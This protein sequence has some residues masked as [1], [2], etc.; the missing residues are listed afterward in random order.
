MSCGEVFPD[1]MT[2]AHRA[3]RRLVSLIDEPSLDEMLS[4]HP[5]D[6]PPL[7]L[8]R[9]SGEMRDARDALENWEASNRV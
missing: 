4:E 8:I 7:Q 3:V 6:P 9:E 1:G 2:H 5:T